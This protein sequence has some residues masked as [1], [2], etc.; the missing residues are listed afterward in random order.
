MGIPGDV[1]PIAVN[2]NLDTSMSMKD[3]EL[4]SADFWQKLADN[5]AK[6]AAEVC[7]IDVSNLDR[8]LQ[9]HAALRAWVNATYELARVADDRAKWELTKA[10]SRALLA[11]KAILDPTTGKNK[12]VPV[13]QAEVDGDEEVQAAMEKLLMLSEKRAALRAMAGALED[14]KDMLIQIASKRRKEMGDH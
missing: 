14:R 2:L 3:V 7:L 11:A 12:T 5:P 13:L 4:G 6:L 10:Q 9:R 8:M 1:G